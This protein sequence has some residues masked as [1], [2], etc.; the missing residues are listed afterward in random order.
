MNEALHGFGRRQMGAPFRGR[1]LLVA[2]AFD[3]R[4]V[5]LYCRGRCEAVLDL[6]WV[7]PFRPVIKSPSF[8][9]KSPRERGS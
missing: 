3:A 8:V 6:P 4:A 2:R 5:R 7:L 9:R 1:I